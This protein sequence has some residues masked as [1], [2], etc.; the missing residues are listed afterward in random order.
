[1]CCLSPALVCLVLN[2]P[3]F[4]TTHEKNA[5]QQ[6]PENEIVYL[7]SRELAMRLRL[8]FETGALKRAG[9]DDPHAVLE[10]GVFV[11]VVLCSVGWAAFFSQ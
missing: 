11:S 8:R 6:K 1:M 9:Q 10:V 2:L 3:P 7:D 5:H 4:T